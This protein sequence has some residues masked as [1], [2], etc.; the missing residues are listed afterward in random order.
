MISFFR[1]FRIKP[2]RGLLTLAQIA[3]GS[4]SVMIVLSIFFSINEHQLKLKRFDLM[5]GSKDGERSAL[6][7]NVDTLSQLKPLIPDVHSISL[8]SMA[9]GKTKFEYKSQFYEFTQNAYVDLNYFEVNPIKLTRGSLFTEKDEA[10]NLPVLL[11][12]DNAATILFADE[13]PIG[14]TLN[15]IDNE[16]TLRRATYPLYHCGYICRCTLK[17]KCLLSSTSLCLPSLLAFGS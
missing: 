11:I 4:L 10:L 13:N 14:Q 5:A 3:L 6:V 9:W 2:F 8:Y 12:T 17:P 15:V 16:N 1:Q 7:F